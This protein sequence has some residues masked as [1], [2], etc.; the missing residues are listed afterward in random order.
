MKFNYEIEN[1]NYKVTFCPDNQDLKISKNKNSYMQISKDLKKLKHDNKILLVIDKNIY[2]KIIKY[3]EH[4]LK[5]SYPNLKV[6]HVQGSKKNK[7]L[8]TFFKIVDKL[9]QEKFSKNSV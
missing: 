8:K 2:S 3:I 9:F 5:K 4:D 6:L 7:N 1:E